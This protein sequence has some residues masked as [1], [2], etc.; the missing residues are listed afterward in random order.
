MLNGQILSEDHLGAI[1]RNNRREIVDARYCPLYL[2]QNDD[3]E[4]W[5][6]RRAIDAHRTNSRLLRKAL[7]LAPRDD[8]AAVLRV[9]GIT[10]TDSF[11]F[12]QDEYSDLTYEKVRFFDN[13]FAEL[14]LRGDPNSFQ[15]GNASSRTPELTNIGSF[16]KCWKKENGSWWLYKNGNDAEQFSELFVYNL[17]KLMGLP[18]AHYEKDGSFIKSKDFTLGKWNFEPMYSCMYDEEDYPLNYQ[19]IHQLCPKAAAQYVSMVYL[20]AL[21]MNMDR[22]TE[23]YGFLLDRESGNIQSLAP[24]FDHNI[25]LISKGYLDNSR[26]GDLLQ[27][28]FVDFIMDTPS[29]L[30][31]FQSL[32]LRLPDEAM[33]HQAIQMSQFSPCKIDIQTEKIMDLVLSA[34]RWIDLEIPDLQQNQEQDLEL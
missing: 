15:K 8:L 10:I 32:N 12:R 3:V 13:D 23:N 1:V 6:R 21:V 33:I 16:E 27:R 18:M 25:A 7:R 28:L 31:D 4:G 11:W 22:H 9:Q 17:G 20:D 2:R 14:A 19:K 5:L 34:K 30:K 26:E 29:A 24:L